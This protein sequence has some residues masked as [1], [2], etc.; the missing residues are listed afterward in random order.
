MLRA[1]RLTTSIPSQIPA[2]S[3]IAVVNISATIIISVT[4]PNQA[5][6]DLMAAMSASNII[7]FM[8]SCISGLRRKY[9]LLLMQDMDQ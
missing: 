7:V 8:I 6:N 3:V 5:G 2:S 9:C 4:V 1:R